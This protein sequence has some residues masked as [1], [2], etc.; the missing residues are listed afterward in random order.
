MLI[1]P[2]LI[3]T[4]GNGSSQDVFGA[5]NSKFREPIQR[6][7]FNMGILLIDNVSTYF[8][9]SDIHT[10]IQYN[11]TVVS[12]VIDGKTREVGIPG[13]LIDLKNLCNDLDI[14]W[15]YLNSAGDAII[16]RGFHIF[17]DI[18]Q[19]ELVVF[20]AGEPTDLTNRPTQTDINRELA[21]RIN[22]NTALTSETLAIPN[23]QIV[24]GTG[25]SVT[26]S[27]DFQWNNSSKRLTVDGD[28]TVGNPLD[29]DIDHVIK[30]QNLNG[31][32][33]Q[34][35]S[36]L[37][38]ENAIVASRGSIAFV[39]DGMGKLYVK[40]VSTGG[41]DEGWNQV[42][43]GHTN[44]ELVYGT[45]RST[46]SS[47]D[48]E[49]NDS[50]KR[51]T[52]NG[53]LVIGSMTGLDTAHVIKMNNASGNI[54]HYISTADPESV[55]TAS[56]GSITYVNDG[57]TGKL[58]LKTTGGS[59]GWNQ[60]TA[61]HTANQIVYGTG[62]TTTS[63]SDFTWNDST[64]RHTVNGDLLI[65]NPIGVVTDLIT[66]F[67]NASASS[68]LFVSNAPPEGVITAGR[69]SMCYYNDGALGKAFVKVL[70]TTSTGWEQ[71]LSGTQS[72]LNVLGL[73]AITQ[74]VNQIKVNIGGNDYYI[75]CSAANTP[76]T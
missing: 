40:T 55:I 64:K 69:G 74:L 52:A 36:I 51:L 65:G 49:W 68:T 19:D 14:G 71:V 43:A 72:T 5:I 45:G 3:T 57:G 25:T 35:I 59:T 37:D 4:G 13:S 9:D 24:F 30:M 32:I 76:L 38:P 18:F 23:R 42:T 39:D 70:N 15:F 33:F 50:S 22:D 60:V 11:S 12:I 47:A 67:R 56:R 31:S 21:L 16:V 41:G 34:Y 54:F 62:R 58:F 2:T 10:A 48:L 28:L 44:R 27:T 61:G 17:G 6:E 26:S 7:Y 73:T 1:T 63:S 46:D 53:E 20:G 66:R 8:F 29:G 75:P